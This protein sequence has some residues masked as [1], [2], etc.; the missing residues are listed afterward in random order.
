MLSFFAREEFGQV[1]DW[2]FEY[3]EYQKL[4]ENMIFQ[5]SVS[6]IV[7]CRL[8]RYLDLMLFLVIGL[9][10]TW[11]KCFEARRLNS[12][13][14]PLYL[15]FACSPRVCMNSLRVLWVPPTVQRHSS[16]GEVNSLTLNVGYDCETFTFFRTILQQHS[17]HPQYPH[18]S[19]SRLPWLITHLVCVSQMSGIVY[20]RHHFANSVY[21]GIAQINI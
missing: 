20:E 2:P 7:N 19:K 1:W 12:R 16:R 8:R 17:T 15:E 14:G 4:K 3:P 18:P 9:F 13:Q 10:C 11:Q 6:C 5:P 21:N